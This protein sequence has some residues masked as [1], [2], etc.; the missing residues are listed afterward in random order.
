MRDDINRKVVREQGRNEREREKE[1]N[2][3]INR[4]VRRQI[5]RKE[6]KE[7]KRELCKYAESSKISKESERLNASATNKQYLVLIISQ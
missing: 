4:Q 1:R 5:D 7:E 2:E 3:Q 6:E